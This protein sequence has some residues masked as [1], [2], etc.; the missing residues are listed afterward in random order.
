[1]MIDGKKYPI[2]W[3]DPK[4][5]PSEPVFFVIQDGAVG[6]LDRAL[7]VDWAHRAKFEDGTPI[8]EVGSMVYMKVPGRDAIDFVKLTIED[9]RDDTT[10][11]VA[12][13]L[14]VTNLITHKEHKY[15]LL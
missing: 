15:E 7:L 10:G 8:D 2:V 11:T 5:Y 6:M 1:M 4:E 14:V 13:T 3:F 9:R 12:A